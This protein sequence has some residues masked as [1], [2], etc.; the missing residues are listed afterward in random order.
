MVQQQERSEVAQLHGAD[1]TPYE[2]SFTLCIDCCE[3]GLSF[4]ME[5]GCIPQESP[6][7]GPASQHASTRMTRPFRKIDYSLNAVRQR[8][9]S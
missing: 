5:M 2:G 7:R 1:G 6:L 9:G 8:T 4:R 3:M